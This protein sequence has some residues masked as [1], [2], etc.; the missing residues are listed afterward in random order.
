M[1]TKPKPTVLIADDQPDIFRLLQLTLEPVDV[2]LLEAD[3]ADDAWRLAQSG[4]PSA[5]ILDIM[6]PGAFDGLEVCRRIKST[7]ATQHCYVILLTARGQMADVEAGE[8]AGADAYVIKPFS[9]LELVSLVE[10]ALG[11]T[12]L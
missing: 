4:R 2:Q 6:M 9:P 7:K 1:N 10:S 5:A 11:R 8:R 3:N 12:H